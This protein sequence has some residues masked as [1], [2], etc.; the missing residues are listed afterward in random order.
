MLSSCFLSEVFYYFYLATRGHRFLCHVFFYLK[1]FTIFI[2]QHEVIGQRSFT[3]VPVLSSCFFNL[4]EVIGQ[5]S[6]LM[7][8][9]LIRIEINPDSIEREL[10]NPNSNPD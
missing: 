5:R 8:R 10:A 6:F 2:W 9:I 4:H 1:V 3:Q 7:L